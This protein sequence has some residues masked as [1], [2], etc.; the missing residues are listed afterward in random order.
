MFM[1]WSCL[2]C[3][4]YYNCCLDHCTIIMTLWQNSVGKGE[5]TYFEHLFLSRQYCLLCSIKYILLNFQIIQFFNEI[6]FKAC[7]L[8]III[9]DE[10]LIS[11]WSF[12]PP[13]ATMFSTFSHRLSWWWFNYRDLL[14]FN[15]I[16]SK[17]SAAELSYE[18]KG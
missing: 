17:S 12:N 15:K 10:L 7:Y 14:F 1:R 8:S 13:F 3:R 9:S 2:C 5:I 4:W 11:R 16:C 18:G 6:S